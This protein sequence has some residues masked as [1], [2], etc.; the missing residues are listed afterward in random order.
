MGHINI[1]QARSTDHKRSHGLYEPPPDDDG[2]YRTDWPLRWLAILGV[3]S[4]FALLV[5]PGLAVPIGPWP[6][7]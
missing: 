4:G 6:A 5:V 2:R 7:S 1:A 3:A